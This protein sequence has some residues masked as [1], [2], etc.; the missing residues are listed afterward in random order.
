MAT[1]LQIWDLY[2]NDNIK[3]RTFAA[4]AKA[5]RDILNEAVPTANLASNANASQANATVASGYGG[6]FW[7]GKICV[8]SDSGNSEE[9]TIKSIVGDVL[10]FTTNLVHS[11]TTANSGKVTFKDNYE[12][13]AW[14]QSTR[15]RESMDTW[16]DTFMYDV[17]SNSTIQAAGEGCSDNDIQF[18]VNSSINAY[19]FNQ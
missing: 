3:G 1:L 4:I 6:I 7:I 8:V 17:I 19:A 15:G 14:A 18:V 13:I 10:T 5:A 11:Y 16:V 9:V 12:R 2:H